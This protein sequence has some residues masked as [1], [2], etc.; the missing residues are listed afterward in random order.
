M[1][2]DVDIVG[3]GEGILF[4]LLV[5]NCDIFDFIDGDDVLVGVLIICGYGMV[6]DGCSVE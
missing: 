2:V 5:F 6:G 1:D 4:L 3:L